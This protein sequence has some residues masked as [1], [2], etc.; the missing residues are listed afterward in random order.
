MLNRGYNMNIIKRE[1]LFERFVFTFLTIIIAIILGCFASSEGGSTWDDYQNQ[2]TELIDGWYIDGQ[3][4]NNINLREN[5]NLVQGETLKMSRIIDKDFLQNNSELCIK[6]YYCDIN[7]YIDGEKIYTYES[8]KKGIGRS[9]G[10]IMLFAG[11]QKFKYDNV[12]ELTIEYIPQFKLDSYNIRPPV[13]GDKGSIIVYYHDKE[14]SSLFISITLIFIGILL[15]CIHTL[16]IRKITDGTELFNIG[17][18]SLLCGIYLIC[19]LEITYLYFSNQKLLYMGEFLSLALIG[20]PLLFILYRLDKTRMKIVYNIAIIINVINFLGQLT[21][22]FLGLRE[23]RAMLNYTHIVLF[24][25]GII[26]VVTVIKNKEEG[27]IKR[28]VIALVLGGMGETILYYLKELQV[29]LSI[30]AGILVFVIIQII[31]QFKYHRKAY[32]EIQEN[33]FY[34]NLAYKDVLTGIY[35]RN[36]YEN[37]ISDIEKNK[38]SYKSIECAVIDLNGLKHTNDT[39]GHM[40]GDELIRNFGQILRMCLSMKHKSYRIGGDEFVI[41]FLNSSKDKISK[42]LREINKKTSEYNLSSQINISY[43]LGRA[44]YD[45]SSHDGIM[46]MI[47]EAD[48]E[49]YKEKVKSKECCI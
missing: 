23:L 2:A 43:S 46:K 26:A 4:H 39:Y 27:I 37:D 18:F 16:A 5:I 48:E 29:G 36:S 1:Y 20:L 21:V 42:I 47:L 44:E 8:N 15:I 35:N 17:V 10:V 25:P 49:M 38:H 40:A 9:D 30:K 3:K 6:T 41:L 28:S 7:V 12:Q 31:Y 45:S 33:Q 32:D 22:Y 24:L 19:Q 34:Q 14:L 11:L 13:V